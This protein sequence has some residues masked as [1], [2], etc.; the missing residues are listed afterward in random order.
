MPRVDGNLAASFAFVDYR[1]EH[2]AGVL[3]CAGPGPPIRQKRY[4]GACSPARAVAGA[5]TDP[6]PGWDELG[7]SMTRL[8]G[9]LLRPGDAELC[10]S[11]TGIDVARTINR[12]DAT[13]RAAED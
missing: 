2:S 9:L 6:A 8:R 1:R 3:H 7:A 5:V 4:Y 10:E 12:Y 11:V 13:F